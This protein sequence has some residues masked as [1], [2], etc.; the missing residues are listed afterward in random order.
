MTIF[1]GWRRAGALRCNASSPS[2]L[3]GVAGRR[4]DRDKRRPA[5]QPV[6]LL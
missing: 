3:E 2:P 5:L 4:R 1:R 6:A